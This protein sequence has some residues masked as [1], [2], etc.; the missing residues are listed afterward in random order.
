MLNFLVPGA[1]GARGG[2]LLKSVAADPERAA[3]RQDGHHYICA[4]SGEGQPRCRHKTAWSYQFLA[5]ASVK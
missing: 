1:N 3:Q 2:L 5:L 4:D